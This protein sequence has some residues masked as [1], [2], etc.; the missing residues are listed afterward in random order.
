MYFW[1]YWRDT[2]RGVFIYLGLLLFFMVVWFVGMFRAN[3]LPSGISDDSAA[4]WVMDVGV[5]FGICYL[6]GLVMSFVTGSN[7]AGTDIGN[8]TGDFLLTRPRSR[9]YFVWAGWI[10]GIFETFALIGLTGFLIFSATLYATH[11]DW[12]QLPSAPPQSNGQILTLPI[13]LAAVFLTAAVIFGLTYFLTIL[14]RG[15][16][17]GVLASLGILFGYSIANSVL[18]FWWHVSL[19]SLNFLRTS[20]DADAHWYQATQFQ[21]AGWTV[22]AL[23][24]PLAAQ[25]IFERR[26]V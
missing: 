21:M 13:A 5:T 7:S 23:A 17:R 18:E 1:K 2:R 6:C 20:M 9:R 3:R 24:F 25:L 15:G 10:A 4:L 8:G 26:D 14:L 12:R 22:V 19:P 16:Q 11:L